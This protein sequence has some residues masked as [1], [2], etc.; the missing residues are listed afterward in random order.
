MAVMTLSA[1]NMNGIDR[2]ASIAAVEGKSNMKKFPGY[3][4]HLV[5]F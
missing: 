1:G 3:Q 2:T 4:V 5:W